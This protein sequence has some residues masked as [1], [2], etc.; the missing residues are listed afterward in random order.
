MGRDEERATGGSGG[1][2]RGAAPALH[3]I[4]KDLSGFF[5]AMASRPLQAPH[6]NRKLQPPAHSPDGRSR[7]ARSANHVLKR[8][9][10]RLPPPSPTGH[11]VVF[12]TCRQR[13]PL[14]IE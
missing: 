12:G 3:G 2:G 13:A 11:A 1:K 7:R 14:S 8:S 5:W 10:F 6:N 9:A 4:P